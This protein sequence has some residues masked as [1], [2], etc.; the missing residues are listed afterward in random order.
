[1]VL[2]VAVVA[3]VREVIAGA[4]AAEVEVAVSGVAV[5]DARDPWGD[6]GLRRPARA[7]PRTASEKRIRALISLL[8]AAPRFKCKMCC[9]LGVVTQ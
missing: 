4:E 2:T 8:S 5:V 7:T 6:S 9:C 1:M 3:A